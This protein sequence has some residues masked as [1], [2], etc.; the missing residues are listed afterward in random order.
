MLRRTTNA[1]AVIEK[2]LGIV[3]ANFFAEGSGEKVTVAAKYSESTAVKYITADTPA[4]VMVTKGENGEYI[5][6]VS[7]PTNMFRNTVVEIE[8]EGVTRV[9]S[10]DSNVRADINDGIISIVANTQNS[11]RATYSITVA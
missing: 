2:K 5:I 11:L 6:S 1:H 4:C 7:D 3:A 10:G 8:I 9:V